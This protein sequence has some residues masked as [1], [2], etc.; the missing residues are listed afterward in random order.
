RAIR[1]AALQL[2][3]EQGL[4]HLTVADISEA[5]D[6]APR[7][8]FNYFSCK[9][10]ALVTDGTLAAAQLC[11]TIIAR[12]R[13]EAPVESLRAAIID[14]TLVAGMEGGREQMLRRQ[15]LV[16]AD[17]ALLAR[18]LAQFATIE[19]AFAEG[20]AERMGLD[21]DDLR[22]ATLAAVALGIVR[23]A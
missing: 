16:Q 2:A 1:D 19:R 18:Q 8:F 5:A 10:D 13:G 14:S 22:P 15:R 6:V 20:V 21:P 3:L 23:V 9:E 12:P 7:T 11:E 17:T 4:E